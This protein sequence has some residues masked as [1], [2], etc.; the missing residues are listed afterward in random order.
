MR[1]KH[2][3]IPVI[4]QRFRIQCFSV[5][6]GLAFFQSPVFLAMVHLVLA[7]YLEYRHI[8]SCNSLQ[9][10]D[11]FPKCQT[12]LRSR[13]RINFNP[14][15]NEVSLVLW[16]WCD[17]GAPLQRWVW[18]AGPSSSCA[19]FWASLALHSGHPHKWTW[20]CRLYR[21]ASP[22]MSPLEAY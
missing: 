9:G 14:L 17:Q 3:P 4:N 22:S 1:N 16:G 15:D 21:W 19:S 5:D 7:L 6:V 8:F 20:R 18:V 10:T 11:Y 13:V 2:I 12:V